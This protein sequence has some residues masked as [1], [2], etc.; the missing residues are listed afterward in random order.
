M[1]FEQA[2]GA[3][4]AVQVLCAY[5]EGADFEKRPPE[6]QYTRARELFQTK[7]VLVVWDNFESVLPAFQARE[8]VVPYPEEERAEIYELF[9]AWT[10]D[11]KGLGR[12]LVTCR[13]GETGLEIGRAHV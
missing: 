1:S 4:P 13:P 11:E 9:R 10:E 12:L 5:F 8:K 6:E 2:G 3:V 7:R